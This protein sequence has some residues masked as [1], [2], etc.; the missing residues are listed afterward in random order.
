MLKPIHIL[1]FSLFI[2][3]TGCGDPEIAIVKPYKDLD[4]RIIIGLTTRDE[5]HALLGEPHRTGTYS[6]AELYI[7]EGGAIGFIAII[8]FP[9]EYI[10]YAIINYDEADR[11][12][13]IKSDWA[14][15][16]YKDTLSWMHLSPIDQEKQ[17]REVDEY[18]AI[19]ESLAIEGDAEEQL[20]MYWDKAIPSS[21]N[22]LC[23][24]ADQNHPDARYRFGILYEHG[25]EGLPQD[26]VRAYYWYT[27]G[28][29]AG[30]Y[31][32]N[33]AAARIGEKLTLEQIEKTQYLIEAWQPGQCQ[34]DLIEA[35]HE[36]T[37]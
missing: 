7:A 18:R 14:L 11:V 26:F 5:V 3:L 33:K 4:E 9:S 10:H 13:S 28:A 22:S 34:T 35:A 8:P 37:K 19:Q 6:K 24:A 12:V 32:S 17:Q 2:N 20:Q 30:S 29:N 36:A 1:L 15:P 31:W 27:L 23:R 16:A 21:H 25:S